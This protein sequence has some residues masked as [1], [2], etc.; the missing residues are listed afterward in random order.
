MTRLEN[1]VK[2]MDFLYRVG[3]EIPVVAATNGT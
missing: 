1:A 3:F 2:F